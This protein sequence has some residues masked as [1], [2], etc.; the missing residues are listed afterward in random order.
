[1]EVQNL[2]PTKEQNLPPREEQVPMIDWQKLN[3]FLAEFR[4]EDP[5]SNSSDM[6]HGL[7][8]CAYCGKSSDEAPIK[9][10]RFNENLCPSCR[11]ELVWHRYHCQRLADETTHNVEQLFSISWKKHIR[12]EKL[13]GEIPADMDYGDKSAGGKWLGKIMTVWGI[14]W[15]RRR[16]SGIAGNISFWQT[17]KNTCNVK[18][19]AETP[20]GAVVAELVYLILSDYMNTSSLDQQTRAGIVAWCMVHYLA[21]MDYMRYAAF[22]DKTLANVY[23]NGEGET[24]PQDMA[25]KIS[26]LEGAG[27]YMEV[28]KLVN[29]CTAPIISLQWIISQF[30]PLNK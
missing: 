25:G 24:P 14:W 12:V 1:M 10:N 20:V 19:R 15:D 26:A 22:Y 8:A 9:A 11:S 27:K 2:L 6:R 5:Q 4:A 23:R 28:Q 16:N 29:P 21:V 3:D 17:K 18:I 7:T 13:I 30:A